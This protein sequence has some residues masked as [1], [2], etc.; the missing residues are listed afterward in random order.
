MMNQLFFVKR[1]AIFW[2]SYVQIDY[3]AHTPCVDTLSATAAPRTTAATAGLRKASV[4]NIHV[5]V[6]DSHNEQ[7]HAQ[8]RELFTFNASRLCEC[9]R[10][11]ARLQLAHS[12]SLRPRLYPPCT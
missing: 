3:L 1:A 4:L 6:I 2:E 11:M 5:S 8:P 12:D 10:R 7:A 9:W